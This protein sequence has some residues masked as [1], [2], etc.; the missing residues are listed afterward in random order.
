M[1][2][3]ERHSCESQLLTTLQDLLSLHDRRFQVDLVVLDF[4]KAFDT[5]PHESL[6]GKLKYYGIDSNINQWFRAFLTNRSQEVMVD[7]SRSDRAAVASGV[8]QGTVLGPLLFLLHINDL[9]CEILSSVRLFA[10]DCLL[11]R[12]ISSRERG[13]TSC[14][15]TLIPCTHGVSVGVCSL[16]WKNVMWCV[17]L[18]V[19]AL[20][21]KFIH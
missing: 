5:V 11:Y 2:S 8:P 21:L 18:G 13:Q 4:A 9:P 12:A 17:L 14:N 10:D 1:D 15:V 3:M 20:L 7:G 16:M 6:L 19:E